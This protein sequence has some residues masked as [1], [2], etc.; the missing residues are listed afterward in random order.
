MPECRINAEDP[1]TFR[2]S[3]GR[4]AVYHPA[5]GPGV[6]MDSHIY[7]G[8]V[9]PPNYDSLIGKLICHAEHREAALVRMHNALTELVIEGIDTNIPL[10]IDLASDAAFRA[11]GTD[12]HSSDASASPEASAGRAM[13][14][15]VEFP[16]AVAAARWL[17]LETLLD[18]PVPSPSP[19]AAAIGPCST[20]PVC[21]EESA[22][23]VFVVEALFEPVAIAPRSPPPCASCSA[24]TS[25][26]RSG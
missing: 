7:A 3:P 15:Y 25:S 5:G 14:D 20:S 19:R 4:I 24:R 8:Y 17:A 10:H 9:V 16:V 2:P 21:S 18:E 13:S 22:W 1:Y 26:P 12:I 6:R 23:S 11:G